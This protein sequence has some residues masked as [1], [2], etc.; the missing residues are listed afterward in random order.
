[1]RIYDRA[2]P[3]TEIEQL[4]FRGPANDMSARRRAD[5]RGGQAG[6]STP[7]RRRPTARV[8]TSRSANLWYLYTPSAAGRATVSLAGSQFDTMLVVYR[9]TA[10]RTPA[11]TGSSAFNDDFNGLTSQLAFDAVA[12]QAY[13]I[14]V[15]GFDSLTGQGLLTVTLRRHHARR[16][17]TWATP[18]TAPTTSANA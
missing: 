5:R 13:L 1:M 2:L 17:P 8:S 12:G 16:R 3:K 11:R 6:R 9:G 18:R 7:A 4:A 14:E 10:G 15:G